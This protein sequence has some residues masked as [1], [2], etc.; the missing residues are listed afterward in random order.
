MAFKDMRM[1]DRICE[2]FSGG[3]TFLTTIARARAG[4]VW[5]NVNRDDAIWQYESSNVLHDDGLREALIAFFLVLRG[6]A[7]TFRFRDHIR[8]WHGM[9]WSGSTL[10]FDAAADVPVF[11]T[12]DGTTTAFQLYIP[13]TA[14]GEVYLR[15]ITKP[16]KIETGY[17][18]PRIYFGNVQQNSGWTLNYST[19]IVTF[20]TPPPN[21]TAIKWAGLF[22]IHARFA[23][24]DLVLELNEGPESADTKLEIVEELDA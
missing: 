2:Q 7:N 14:G 20:N 23:S 1:P 4:Y 17:T 12:G 3:P 18:G 21:G 15:K 22:D 9:S 24:D 10:A 5:T 19:G 8:Y 11:A 16:G 13:Y 6:M